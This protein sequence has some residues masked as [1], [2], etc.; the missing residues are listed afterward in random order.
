MLADK[1]APWAESGEVVD[2]Y[3]LITLAALDIVAEAAMGC[4]VS[5]R[6]GDARIANWY[7]NVIS[8]LKD[9]YLDVAYAG[10]VDVCGYM[11]QHRD[12]RN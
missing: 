9:Y 4:E 7:R 1:L 3:P 10:I 11:H 12:R 2:V 8:Y 5:G 6:A